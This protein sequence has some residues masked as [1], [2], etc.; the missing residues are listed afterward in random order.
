MVP[1]EDSIPEE[2][3]R[4]SRVERIVPEL[5]RRMLEA[6]YEK[7]S[8]G[9]ENLRQFVSDLKLPKEALAVLLTQVEDGR[10][11]LYRAVAGEVREFLQRTS[12]SDE[13]KR[14]VSGLTLEIKTEIRVVPKDSP[15]DSVR[16][17]PPTE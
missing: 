10:H 15:K 6:G 16:P 5:L 8:D 13:I 14:A 1:P 3:E 9:P 12:L 7:L 17:K 2:H 4:E 11:G